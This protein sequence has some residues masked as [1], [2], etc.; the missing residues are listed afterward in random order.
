MALKYHRA[1]YKQLPDEEAVAAAL[2]E[3]GVGLGVYPLPYVLDLEGDP[4]VELAARPDRR[5]D[6]RPGHRIHLP[7][8]LAGR[9]T[10]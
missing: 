8:A 1:D 7:P 6:L 2:R 3:A 5:G 4:V 10:W 9:L